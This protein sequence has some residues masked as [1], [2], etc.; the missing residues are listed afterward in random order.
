M[1]A[2]GLK[3][4]KTKEMYPIRNG[5]IHAPDFPGLGLDINEE[6]VESFR[7]RT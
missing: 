7:V 3:V 2:P 1:W 6:A 4:L 5:Y